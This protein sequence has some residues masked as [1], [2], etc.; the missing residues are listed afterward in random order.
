MEHQILDVRGEQC[1]IPVVKAT[2]ALEK[3]QRG[4]LEVH[5][6]NEMAVQNLLRMASGR[7]L[8]AE[9]TQQDQA[10]YIVTITVGEAD[11]AACQ[12]DCGCAPMEN[13]DLVSD[14]VVAIDTDAMGRGSKKLGRT[15][16][17]GFVYALSQLPQPPQCIL[18]YNGGVHLAVEGS[19]SLQDL[20]DMERRGT[21]ILVCGTC[22]NYYELQD[23]LAVGSVTN[24]Y[25]IVEKLNAAKKVIKP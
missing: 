17:K 13:F 1:P 6:D 3:M 9:H 21:E 5:V 23:Q 7:K 22:L 8:A 19:D 16:L 10:H 4:V 2:R 25:S 14:T 12:E 15:L 20:Q 24:M 18:M 11:A